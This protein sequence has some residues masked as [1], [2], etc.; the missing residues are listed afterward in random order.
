MAGCLFEDIKL[1]KFTVYPCGGFDGWDIYRGARTT[2][3]E[4]KYNKYKGK[5]V[6]GHGATFSKVD[7]PEALSLDSKAITSDYYAFLAGANQFE[8]PEKYVINLFAT[9]GIDYVNN[10]LLTDEIFDMVQEKRGD[11]LYVVTTPDKPLGATDA[12]DEMFTSADAAENLNET[13]IDTYFG[14]TY[15]P[16][17]KYFDADNNTY[18]NLPATKDVLRNMADVDNKKYPW[19]APAGLER[20]KVEC[21]KMHFFAKLEDEDTL[22]DNRI[23]PLKTF[24]EDGVKVWGNKTMYTGDTPMNRVNVVR[25]MLYM[26]T[27]ISKAA[28][29]MIFDP[30]DDMLATEFDGMLRPILNQ[31]KSD[32]GIHDY[33][34]K[35]SQTPEQI[36]AHE[37][38]ANILIKP[39]AA[40]EYIEINFTVTPYGVSFDDM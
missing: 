40:L 4:F 39:V 32:R 2:G 9:P 15:Y 13:G 8:I 17:V 28:R 26:R 10:T 38:S 21:K 36:D 20:G 1:R 25:L 3:D 33:R 11:S 18:I 19:Y 23:N 12:M 27:L 31:I 5:I 24:S 34:L 37:I 14:A 35:V 6:N 30:Q 7:N 29:Q 22:Y 16:W